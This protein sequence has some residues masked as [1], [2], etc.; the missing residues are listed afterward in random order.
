VRHP[1]LPLAFAVGGLMA[2]SL[3][4][5]SEF[6]TT[7]LEE[8]ACTITS[9]DLVVRTI[10]ERLRA[11]FQPAMNLSQDSMHVFIA[12]VK[13]GKA[14]T[15]VQRVTALGCGEP[16]AFIDDRYYYY[17]TPGVLQQ[18]FAKSSHLHTIHDAAVTDGRE[19]GQRVRDAILATI[20]QER[21]LEPDGKN[22][23][24]GGDPDVVLVTSGSAFLLI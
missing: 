1:K 16:T 22:K 15:G 19:V 21:A 6:S 4:N 2:F 9:T 17:M 10:A 7:Y 8:F 12:L 23:V 13:D 14:D 11:R 24:I 20:A 3:G 5:R 18:L